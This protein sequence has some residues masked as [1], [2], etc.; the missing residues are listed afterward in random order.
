LLNALEKADVLHTTLG[1][2]SG[3]ARGVSSMLKILRLVKNESVNVTVV[4]RIEEE[5]LAELKRVM[6]AEGSDHHK[7]LNLKDVTLVDQAAIR[8]LTR[9]ED[10]GIAFEN[11]PPYIRDWITAERRRRKGRTL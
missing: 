5:G 8:F 2:T 4:G 1:E 10:E 7:I 3:L 6:G 11:C 9:C